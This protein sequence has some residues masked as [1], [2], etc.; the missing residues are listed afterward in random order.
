MRDNRPLSLGE[1]EG[2]R[3]FVHDLNPRWV[4]PGRKTL[5]KIMHAMYRMGKGLVSSIFDKLRSDEPKWAKG[6]AA[7]ISLDL[8]TSMASKSYGAVIIHYMDDSFS[9][10]SKVLL[11]REIIDK[12]HTAVEIKAM[13]DVALQEANLTIAHIGRGVHDSGSNVVKAAKDATLTSHLCTAHGLQRCVA[14]GLKA[15]PGMRGSLK[16]SSRVVKYFNKSNVGQAYFKEKQKELNLFSH[17]LIQSNH[18]RWHSHDAKATRCAEQRPALEGV[19]SVDNLRP[20]DKRIFPADARLTDLDFANLVDFS[21]CMDGIRQVTVELQSE[22]VT[23]SLVM[24]SILKLKRQLAEGADIVRRTPA[25]GPN[26][27]AVEVVIKERDLTTPAKEMRKALRGDMAQRFSWKFLMGWAICSA[28]DPRTKALGAYGLT[29]RQQKQVWKRVRKELDEAISDMKAAGVYEA[30]HT[31]GQKRDAEGKSK[32]FLAEENAAAQ[33]SGSSLQ[34]VMMSTDGQE[35]QHIL[36]DNS[37]ER[38][39]N[40]EDIKNELTT[41]ALTSCIDLA[42][43]PLAWWASKAHEFPGLARLAMFYLS[44]PATSAAVERLFSFTGLTITQLRSCLSSV[45][46]EELVFLRKNWDDRYYSVDYHAPLNEAEE[47]K[48]AEEPDS[49]GEEDYLDGEEV[50]EEVD[51]VD[52]DDIIEALVNDDALNDDLAFFRFDEEEEEIATGI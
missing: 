15:S 42:D 39:T 47:M 32:N 43:D 36:G 46:L 41:Y 1:G 33:A 44:I 52:F 2:F 50:V 13:M 51:I 34:N 21:S 7:H 6:M 20:E 28:L 29:D 27:P 3:R 30:A 40:A 9:L 25:N 16:Q 17:K 31:R 38:L 35:H 19:W 48:A 37:R 11:C 49:E 12:H 8:W 45:S 14:A 5:R 10:G 26:A 18:T 23:S 24:P 22:G 4:I